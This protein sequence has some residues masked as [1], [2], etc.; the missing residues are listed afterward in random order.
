MAGR[1]PETLTSI[2]IRTLPVSPSGISPTVDPI[3]LR[4]VLRGYFHV[5]NTPVDAKAIWMLAGWSGASFTHLSA[6]NV[7]SL[8]NSPRRGE[9][10]HME[11]TTAALSDIRASKDIASCWKGETPP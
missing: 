7:A 1:K 4:C 5:M 8:L 2:Q 6:A 9:V 3:I 11:E 10:A